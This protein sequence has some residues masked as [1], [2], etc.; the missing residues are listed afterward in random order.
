MTGLV[1]DA[2]VIVSTVRAL[3][4][5]GEAEVVEG[6]SELALLERGCAN[7]LA[8]IDIVKKSG[9]SPVVCINAFYTDKPEEHELIKKL[10]AGTRCA[11]SSHWQH[12]GVGAKDLAIAVHEA[13]EEK[14]S[15]KFL[16]ELTT[17]L[18]ERVEKICKEVYGA[19]GVEWNE[20]ANKK[21]MGF[22]ADEAVKRY[23]VCMV[24]TQMSLSHDPEL[25]NRPTGFKV[26]IRDVMVYNG[27]QL[28]VPIAGDIKLLPGT[29]SDPA[30]R[31][32]DVDCD[33][34]RVKGLF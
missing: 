3:K 12:G 33:S 21:I 16:Y 8:H 27:A 19:D 6:E 18:K 20:D 10:C 32:I 28:V 30:Y 11:V 23:P 17:P 22:E 31:R 15:F 14:N 29:G 26:P 7:L 9:T 25:R 13:C 24:K 2:V 1:P 34:G 4:S 5:H